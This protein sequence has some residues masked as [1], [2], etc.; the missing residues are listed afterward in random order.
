MP[1]VTAR[2]RGFHMVPVVSHLSF[3]PKP[4]VSL[5]TTSPVF[6]NEAQGIEFW[7]HGYGIFRQFSSCLGE[8]IELLH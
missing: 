6:G 5:G 7:A 8:T 4:F 1:A 2:F 3:V